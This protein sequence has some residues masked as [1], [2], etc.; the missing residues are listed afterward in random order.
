MKVLRDWFCLRRLQLLLLLRL[1]VC[2]EEDGTAEVGDDD[3]G[4]G[5]DE[6]GPRLRTHEGPHFLHDR[7][8]L[9]VSV[10]LASTAY[11]HCRIAGLKDQSVSWY[12]KK[13]DEIHLITFGFQTYHNDDR[14]ALTFEQPS[15]WRLRIRYVQRR[16][17]GTYQCQVSTHPPLIRSIHLQVV[18]AAIQI[19]DERGVELREKFYRAGSTIELQCHVAD[20][21]TATSLQMAWYHGNHRLNYDDSRGGVSVKTELRGSVARSWLRVSNAVRQDSGTY[22]CNVTH[23]AATSVTI[24]VVPD[25]YP[26]AIQRG[27][28]ASSWRGIMLLA[29]LASSFLHTFLSCCSPPHR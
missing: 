8:N 6:G 13:G 1:A 11:L 15:D 25:E 29:C 19:L 10:Q 18:E 14:F 5:G 2:L 7:L 20:V 28:R 17:E 12:R 3:A 21:P 22:Y 27:S 4:G 16:D 9:N 24:H 26:A 23:L